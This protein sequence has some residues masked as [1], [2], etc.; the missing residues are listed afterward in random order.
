MITGRAFRRHPAAILKLLPEMFS[1]PDAA[2]RRCGC[3]I[4]GWLHEHL[5]GSDLKALALNDPSMIVEQAAISA[6]RRQAAFAAAQ[7][8]RTELLGAT[9]MRAWTYAD[10]LA[11]TADPIVLSTSNDPLCIWSAVEQQ[12]ALLRLHVE[13][14]LNECAKAVRERAESKTRDRQDDPE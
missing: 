4:A 6:L 2:M 12:P 1:S 11:E 3:E 8:L 13:E 5:H 9:G 10:A 14:K 7:E